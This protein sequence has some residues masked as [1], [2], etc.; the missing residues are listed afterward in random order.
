[1]GVESLR[2]PAAPMAGTAQGSVLLAAGVLPVM[3]IV[4]LVPVLPLLLAE[5]GTAPGAAYLVP[6]AV[7]VPALCVAALS[8]LAGW[9]LDRGGRKQMLVA[10]LIGY[11][12]VGITPFVLRPLPVLLGARILLGVMEAVVMTAATTLIGDYFTGATRD[13]WISRQM[14]VVSL[15]AIA[16]AA[17]GGV[18]GETL[19]SRGPFLLYALGL[20]VALAA[21]LL[22]PEPDLR[23]PGAG[24][25]AWRLD[26]GVLALLA[27]TFA[28]S[29]VFYTLFVQ[30]GPLLLESGPASPAM[31]GGASAALNLGIAVGAMLFQWQKERTGA[32]LLAAGLILSAVGYLGAARSSDFFVVTAWAIVASVGC[33]L[34]LPNMLAWTLRSLPASHR[35]R[36]TGGWT[37]AFFLGQFVAPLIAT[38]LLPWTGRLAGVLMLYAFASLAAAVVAA[39]VAARRA[40]T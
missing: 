38:A 40:R 1:M 12:L 32:A 5:F 18:L 21:A 22:L 19:G 10:A 17:L 26:G 4:S 6:I 14:I 7:T 15:A 23:T 11:A 13:R 31:I 16:L 24:P 25:V 30:I 29:L 20:P 39:I 8:P 34:L 27:I 3:A 33:G 37:G 28:I 35:G 9:L 36:V 2:N